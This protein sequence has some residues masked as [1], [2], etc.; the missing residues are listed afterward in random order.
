[1]CRNFSNTW[2]SI[3]SCSLDQTL[4]YLIHTPLARSKDRA[5]LLAEPDA[6]CLFDSLVEG[7]GAPAISWLWSCTQPLMSGNID[8]AF[9]EGCVVLEQ[10]L[11]PK[12]DLRSCLALTWSQHI[13]ASVLQPELS[14]FLGGFRQLCGLKC[15]FEVCSMFQTTK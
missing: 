6:V 2:W 13:S 14:V 1:M 8:A 12:I 10:R 7:L 9:T 11:Q 4:A 3:I 15:L 5:E